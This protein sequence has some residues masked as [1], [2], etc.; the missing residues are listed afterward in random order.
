M[1]I[2]LSPIPPFDFPAILKRP[3]SRPARSMIVSLEE[4]SVVFAIQIGG[5][6]VPIGIK[7]GGTVDQPML[8][9]EMPDGLS[10]SV[11]E[12]ALKRVEFIFSTSLDMTPVYSHYENVSE[13]HILMQRFRGLKP[14][15]DASL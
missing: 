5:N 12:E 3:A 1:L 2:T 8:K 14:I 9:V 15:R 4:R 11:Y 6:P 10:D 7:S 13:I